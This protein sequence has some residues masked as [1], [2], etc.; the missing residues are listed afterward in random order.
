MIRYVLAVSL[1]NCFKIMHEKECFHIK[2]DRKFILIIPK[3][4]LREKDF[5][6]FSAVFSGHFY[7]K[8]AIFVFI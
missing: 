5:F 3:C 1:F 4:I 7:E 2:Y 8:Y 6:A